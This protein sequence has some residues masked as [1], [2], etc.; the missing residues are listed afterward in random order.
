MGCWKSKFDLNLIEDNMRN[1]IVT[2]IS[3]ISQNSK[4]LYNNDNPQAE[5]ILVQTSIVKPNTNCFLHFPSKL[6]FF[7]LEGLKSLSK[8]PENETEI[9]RLL[10]FIEPQEQLIDTFII[11]VSHAWLGFPFNPN[12]S[13]IF[14]DCN[15]VSPTKFQLLLNGIERIYQKYASN[16]NRVLI[17]IDPFCSIQ[18]TVSDI[19]NDNNRLI[20]IPGTAENIQNFI[21]IIQYCDCFLMLINDTQCKDTYE[22]SSTS[23]PML[24]DHNYL[25]IYNSLS[26]YNGSNSYLNQAWC[27]IE[28]LYSYYYPIRL[29]QNQSNRMKKFSLEFLELIKNQSTSRPHFIFGINESESS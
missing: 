2:Q 4:S 1:V 6:R 8:F 3:P 21:N 20:N 9:N 27:R 17:W 14:Q 28:L 15:F 24:Q 5:N 10:V 23:S 13:S 18:S 16:M 26:S 19:N 22:D 12:G 25:T 29:L 7:Q 11:Y